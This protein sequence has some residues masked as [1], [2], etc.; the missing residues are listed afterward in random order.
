MT[1]HDRALL[2]H[3]ADKGLS[4]DDLTAWAKTIPDIAQL[5][6]AQLIERLLQIC[7]LCSSHDIKS[8][9]Q[10]VKRGKA[11]QAVEAFVEPPL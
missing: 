9:S 6:A 4:L 5:S 1:T 8:E 7:E 10:T 11:G 2:R 3:V